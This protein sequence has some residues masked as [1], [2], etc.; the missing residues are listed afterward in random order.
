M[1]KK[2][3]E[4]QVIELRESCNYLRKKELEQDKLIIYLKAREIRDFQN[5]YKVIGK[6]KLEFEIYKFNIEFPNG[7][8]YVDNNWKVYQNIYNTL[9]YKYVW[10]NKE[11]E[12]HE[13]KTVGIKASRCNDFIAYSFIK[14]ETN[15][16]YVAVCQENP[17]GDT[18]IKSYFVINAEKD[19]IVEIDNGDIFKD[20]EWKE[21]K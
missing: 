17:H 7:Q 8:V 9:A 3:L 16:I 2:E 13:F 21:L 5:L 20:C 18:D 15:K 11:T 19:I 10:Y 4:A 1:K 6:Y 12:E 14:S